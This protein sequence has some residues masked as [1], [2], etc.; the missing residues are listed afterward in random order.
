M[1]WCVQ[2]VYSC[3]YKPRACRP[4][5][6]PRGAA[7]P[8]FGYAKQLD[9]PGEAYFVAFVDLSLPPLPLVPAI[10]GHRLSD[11]LGLVPAMV[12]SAVAAWAGCR[13]SPPP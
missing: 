12:T 8:S 4:E 2:Q 11:G 13:S 3:R 9:A 6:V 1:P 7:G 10:R 5:P